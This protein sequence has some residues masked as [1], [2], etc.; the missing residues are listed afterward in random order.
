MKGREVDLD[1]KKKW[2]R[3]IKKSDPSYARYFCAR[4][5]R[6]LGAAGKCTCS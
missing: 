4:C 6:Y 2:L 3:R 1:E 5:V